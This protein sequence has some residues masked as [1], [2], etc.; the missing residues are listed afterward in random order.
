MIDRMYAR[1]LKERVLVFA[2]MAALA[3]CGGTVDLS[4]DEER[5]YQAATEHRR[6]EAPEGL[7]QLDPL[8]EIPMPEASPRAPR[9]AGSPCLDR[10]PGVRL[11]SDD[12]DDEEEGGEE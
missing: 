9:P 11:S 4:C 10:P 1:K 3:G 6:V 8:K 7:S 5:A 12:D 2:A